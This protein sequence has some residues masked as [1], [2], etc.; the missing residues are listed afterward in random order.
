MTFAQ[1]SRRVENPLATMNILAC[2]AF[3]H[4]APCHYLLSNEGP[5]IKNQIIF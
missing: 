3:A 4:M 2:K 1:A 5:G